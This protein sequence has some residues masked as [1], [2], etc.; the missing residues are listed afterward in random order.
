[1]RATEV[2][3]KYDFYS[4]TYSFAPQLNCLMLLSLSLSHTHPHTDTQKSY[5]LSRN[6]E[7]S[8]RE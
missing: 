5:R 8:T 6:G 7:F 3:V 1:M 4:I 2:T